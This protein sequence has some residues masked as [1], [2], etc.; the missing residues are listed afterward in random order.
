MR[1]DAKDI[2]AFAKYA[3]GRGNQNSFGRKSASSFRS[4]GG[5]AISVRDAFDDAGLL[6]G[7]DLKRRLAHHGEAGGRQREVFQSRKTEHKVGFFEINM[8][9]GFRNMSHPVYG[10]SVRGRCTS[11]E[12]RQWPV[13]F[14]F[15]SSDLTDRKM[16]NTDTR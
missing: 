11:F 9:I 1:R 5:T 14:T 7:R 4:D 15:R 8:M 3:N 6:F 16:A 13:L 10:D 2:T 12:F